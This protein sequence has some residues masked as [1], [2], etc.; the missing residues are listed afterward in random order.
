MGSGLTQKQQMRFDEQGSPESYTHP[1]TTTHILCRFSHHLL[2][3]A[4]TVQDAP[5]FRIKRCWVELLELLVGQ[6]KCSFI[7]IIRC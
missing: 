1:P 2:R 7:Y 3:E 4:E 5:R 6:V